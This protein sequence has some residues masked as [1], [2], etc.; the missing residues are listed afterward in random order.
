MI[1]WIIDALRHGGIQVV[2]ALGGG[3]LGWLIGYAMRRGRDG[4]YAREVASIPRALPGTYRNQTDAFRDGQEAMRQAAFQ[5]ARRADA[6]ID[7]LEAELR[8]RP[9]EE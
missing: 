2:M 6:E 8:A 9:Y 5:V 3:L 1:D 7:R 4:R